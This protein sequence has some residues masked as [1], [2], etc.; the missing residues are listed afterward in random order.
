CV[1][2]PACYVILREGEAGAD[3][4]ILLSGRCEVLVHGEPLGLV[5][6]GE[7]FGELACLGGGTRAATGRAALDSAALV[8]A[9]EAVRAELLRSPAL[10]DRFLGAMAQRVRDISRREATVR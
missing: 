6:P 9:G 2:C 10:L 1:K 7:L 5:G 8:L 4:F 3:A